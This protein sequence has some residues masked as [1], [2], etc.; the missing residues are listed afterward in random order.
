[1]AV[2]LIYWRQDTHTYRLRLAGNFSMFFIILFRVNLSQQRSPI[3]LFPVA[4]T[5]TDCTDKADRECLKS[6]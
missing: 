5:Y 6:N 3:L 4:Y 1:M 2:I